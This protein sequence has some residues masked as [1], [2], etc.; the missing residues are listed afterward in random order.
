MGVHVPETHLIELVGDEIED[1]FPV[2]L[3]G[4][5]AIAVTPTKLFQG[6][7]QIA[8][9]C[10]L[11]AAMRGDSREGIHGRDLFEDSRQNG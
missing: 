11:G 8:H 3:G 7:V 6:I 1:L 5:A 2:G 9:W 4:V 10:L